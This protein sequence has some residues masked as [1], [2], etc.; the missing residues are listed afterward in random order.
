MISIVSGVTVAVASVVA[1]AIVANASVNESA[2][3]TPT[4]TSI[5]VVVPQPTETPTLVPTQIPTPEEPTPILLPTFVPLWTYTP[6]PTA[7]ARPTF[8]PFPTPLALPTYTPLP[9]FTPFPTPTA[10][11][12]YTPLPTGTP[13]PTFTPQPTY[14]LF[15]TP[16]VK[17]TAIRVLRRTLVTTTPITRYTPIPIP[18][19]TPAAFTPENYHDY[20][21]LLDAYVSDIMFLESPFELIP[22][23]E[24]VYADKFDRATAR[25]IA[26]ELHFNFPSPKDR[27]EFMIDTIYY[28]EDGSEFSRHRAAMYVEPWWYSAFQTSGWGWTD[29]GLWERGIFRVDLS[30]EG[31]LVAIGEFQVREYPSREH[32]D[33]VWTPTVDTLSQG[34]WVLVS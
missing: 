8:T 27:G 7:T 16:T 28:W 14:T 9:T 20:I 11:P 4:P 26:W 25:Y 18:T 12:T 3:S 15:P 29:L 24:R 32:S 22:E 1:F 31:T 6:F 5:V 21:S 17:P 30:V 2:K 10:L 19:A 13:R 23:S 34:N 33:P